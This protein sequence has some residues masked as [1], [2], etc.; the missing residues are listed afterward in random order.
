MILP[1]VIWLAEYKIHLEMTPNGVG[2]DVRES[3]E[4]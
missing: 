3:R 2:S 4:A 1:A